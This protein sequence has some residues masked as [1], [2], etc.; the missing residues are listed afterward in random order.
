MTAGMLVSR[1]GRFAGFHP[2]AGA[3]YRPRWMPGHG[4]IIRD[5]LSPCVFSSS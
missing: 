1:E 3:A 5:V 2:I 4:R